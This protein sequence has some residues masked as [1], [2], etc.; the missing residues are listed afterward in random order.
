MVLFLTLIS[1]VVRWTVSE[2]QYKSYSVAPDP[3]QTM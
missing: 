2:F 3:D 1:S